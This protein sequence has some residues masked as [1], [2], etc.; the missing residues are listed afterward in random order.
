MFFFVQLTAVTGMMT[1]VEIRHQLNSRTNRKSRPKTAGT[2]TV[3]LQVCVIN[4][5]KF[6][7]LAHISFTKLTTP[8][9]IV[10]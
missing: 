10:I 1:L 4:A 8:N 9:P 6:L 2:A 5:T 7:I 3:A